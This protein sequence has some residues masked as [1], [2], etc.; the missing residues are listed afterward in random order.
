MRDGGSRE[1]CTF[2]LHPRTLEFRGVP[3]Y[4]CQVRT[5]GLFPTVS[6]ALPATVCRVMRQCAGEGRTMCLPYPLPTP[7][8]E[9]EAV[10]AG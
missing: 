2:V 6:W 9:R 3:A 5:E 7:G 8:T 10:G 4:I 1:L